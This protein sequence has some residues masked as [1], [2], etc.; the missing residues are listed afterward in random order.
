MTYLG[1]L[2]DP[3]C[4]KMAGTIR[5]E[6]NADGGW[7]I[8]PGRTVGDQRHR[9]GVLRSQADGHAGRPPP[10]G[11]GPRGHLPLGGARACNSFTRF[12]LALLGQMTYDEVPHVPPEL[13]LVPAR[14]PFSLASMSSWTRT[15]IVPL[16]I[17]SA[18]K[19]VA[20]PRP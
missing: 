19:P 12:Y 13:M 3:M 15:I 7:S 20:D 1:R 14:F 6:Q 5:D 18:Y 10:H 9:Q 4:V 8:Y 2:N 16:M 11:Q 17:I